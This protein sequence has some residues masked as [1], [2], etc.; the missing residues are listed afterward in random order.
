MGKSA[1]EKVSEEVERR[2]NAGSPGDLGPV[3]FTSGLI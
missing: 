3:V 2:R 1:D